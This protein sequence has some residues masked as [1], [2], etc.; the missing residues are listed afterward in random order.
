LAAPLKTERKE[1]ASKL[2]LQAFEG[3]E[4]VISDLAFPANVTALEL[5]QSRIAQGA[6]LFVSLARLQL[7]Q[8]TV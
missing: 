6:T 8:H 4:R 3:A 5:K 2:R 7:A 1:L